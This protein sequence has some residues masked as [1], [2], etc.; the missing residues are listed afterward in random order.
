MTDSVVREIDEITNDSLATTYR[1]KELITTTC[2]VA[3][4]VRDA[5]EDQTSRLEHIDAK[6]NSIQ[7]TSSHINRV[8][9]KMSRCCLCQCWPVFRRRS[10]FTNKVIENIEMSTYNKTRC[11][12]KDSFIKHDARENEMNNNLKHVETILND[13]NNQAV[14]IGKELDKQNPLITS[15]ADKANINDADLRAMNIKSRN[16]I[17]R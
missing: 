3:H 7:T 6:M 2:I 5:L 13:I 8:L 17:V 1:M 10:K 16:I 11:A 12:Q 14:A 15:L 9:T 4:T